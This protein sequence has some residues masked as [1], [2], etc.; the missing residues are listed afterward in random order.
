MTPIDIIKKSELLILYVKTRGKDIYIM[1]NIT[2]EINYPLMY[3]A[4][5]LLLHL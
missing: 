1:C 5:K 2:G 4:N 3:S